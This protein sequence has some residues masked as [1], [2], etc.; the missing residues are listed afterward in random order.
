MDGGFTLDRTLAQRETPTAVRP[1]LLD[2]PGF[3]RDGIRNLSQ[4]V[5]QGE[6]LPIVFAGGALTRPQLSE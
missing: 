1:A 3:D 4:D 6:V 2:N 5:D